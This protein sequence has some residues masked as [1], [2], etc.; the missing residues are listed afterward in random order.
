MEVA[1]AAVVAA[2]ASEEDLVAAAIASKEGIR[3]ARVDSEE[4][5]DL[6]AAHIGAAAGGDVVPVVMAVDVSVSCWLP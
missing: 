5:P 4:A 6:R 1:L 3:T 2:A